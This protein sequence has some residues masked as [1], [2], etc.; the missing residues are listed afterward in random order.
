LLIDF[1]ETM[2]KAVAIIT[3]TSTSND[4]RGCY[5][6]AVCKNAQCPLEFRRF[7]EDNAS[8][9]LSKVGQSVCL[10]D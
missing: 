4:A 10:V 9:L 1:S 3:R 5:G 8:F 7:I 2:Y 6:F